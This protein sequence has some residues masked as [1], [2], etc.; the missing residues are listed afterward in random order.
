MLRA[1]YGRRHDKLYCSKLKL[2]VLN[3]S[4]NGLLLGCPLSNLLVGISKKFVFTHERPI[5]SNSFEPPQTNITRII[6]AKKTCNASL[7][8]ASISNPRKLRNSSNNLLDRKPTSHIY[9]HLHHGNLS[10]SDVCYLFSN[11]IFKLH[12]ALKSIT[13]NF[14]P[15]T[16]TSRHS[17]L[18]QSQLHPP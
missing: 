6:V 15:H 7:I 16:H 13:T 14:S 5:I 9:H 18:M 17:I 11:K 4:T 2:F 10:L 8:T 3:L 12:T 1:I